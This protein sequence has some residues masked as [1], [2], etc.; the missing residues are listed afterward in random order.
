[1]R[2][3]PCRPASHAT[4]PASDVPRPPRSHR[5][6]PRV[7]PAR[8]DGRRGAAHIRAFVPDLRPILR[9]SAEA[10]EQPYYRTDTHWNAYGAALAWEEASGL[11][12]PEPVP[13]SL[14]HGGDL[15]RMI[16]RRD[17]MP[18]RSATIDQTLGAAACSRSD[19][20]PY[21][22]DPLDPVRTAR[23]TCRTGGAAGQA[24]VVMDS[25]GM[26]LIPSVARSHARSVFLWRDDVPWDVVREE[27]PDL[28][29]RVVVERNL[30]VSGPGVPGEEAP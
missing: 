25:F 18:E 27:E 11:A 22:F 7:R 30:G 24:V 13:L 3:P 29:L 6:F 19:G 9:R 2:A 12:A 8:P 4:P 10:G 16:G 21:A 17:A 5:P 23:I 26:S 20:A 1:M 14:P 15:A 28:L